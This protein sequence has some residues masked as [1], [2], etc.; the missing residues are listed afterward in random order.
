M[1]AKAVCKQC[2]ITADKRHNKHMA[3]I[4][5]EEAWKR[6]VC[7]CPHFVGGLND[8]HITRASPHDNCPYILEQILANQKGE[9]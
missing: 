9:L 1:L 4:W 8:M 7:Y 6:Q 3:H 2:Y 5:F